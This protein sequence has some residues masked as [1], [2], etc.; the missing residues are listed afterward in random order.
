[1]KI[2]LLTQWF[3]P[4]PTFKGLAFAKELKRQGHDVQVLTGFPNYPGGKIYDGYK[5]K[6]YQHEEVDGISILRVALYPN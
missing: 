6:L 3:D 2:L 5:L 1:M 4:E